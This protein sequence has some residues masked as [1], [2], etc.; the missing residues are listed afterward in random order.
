MYWTSFFSQC[1]FQLGIFLILVHVFLCLFSFMETT[2]ISVF[3]FYLPT[4]FLP[5]LQLICN[6][7]PEFLLPWKQFHICSSIPK[8]LGCFPSS[9]DFHGEG[10]VFPNKLLLVNTHLVTCFVFTV[11]INFQTF[12][13]VDRENSNLTIR[14]F[15]ADQEYNLNWSF[16]SNL[17]IRMAFH[18]KPSS[19][20]WLQVLKESLKFD[21]FLCAHYSNVG[22]LCASVILTINM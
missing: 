1:L 5:S 6:I 15:K 8:Q 11:R 12:T 22:S 14:S 19:S 17:L 18:S 20:F 16:N 10:I 21:K 7:S 13:T 4:I 2:I 9:S 3:H